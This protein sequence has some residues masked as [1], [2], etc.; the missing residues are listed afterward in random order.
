MFEDTFCHM[1]IQLN[2]TGHHFTDELKM[3]IK[4]VICDNDNEHSEFEEAIVAI[5]IEEESLKR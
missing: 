2:D 1:F 3:E 4:K 5:T